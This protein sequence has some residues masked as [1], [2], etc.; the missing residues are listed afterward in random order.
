MIHDLIALLDVEPETPFVDPSHRQ[1]LSLHPFEH[2]FRMR[3][4]A[5]GD[6]LGAYEGGIHAV[7]F[8]RLLGLSSRDPVL[9]IL[10]VHRPRIAAEL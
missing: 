4:I 9:A 3:G 7:L 10:F 1:N 2:G 5:H 6:L 8:F